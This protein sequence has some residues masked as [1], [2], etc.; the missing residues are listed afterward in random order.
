L[1]IGYLLQSVRWWNVAV[2]TLVWACQV[3][4]IRAE[5]RLLR[6]DADYARY[7]QRTRFKLVPGLW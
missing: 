1:Q 2:F 6:E 5:E 7:T 4:R 3:A